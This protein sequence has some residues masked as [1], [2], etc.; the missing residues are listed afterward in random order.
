M[1]DVNNISGTRVTAKRLKWNPPQEL[2]KYS[3]LI[4]VDSSFHSLQT[5][6][7][8][9]HHPFGR[10]NLEGSALAEVVDANPDFSLFVRKNG[11]RTTLEEEV[12]AVM[13]APKLNPPATIRSWDNY[14]KAANLYPK[15]NS[16][17]LPHTN[18]FV[19][20]MSDERIVQAGK[21]LFDVEMARG[22]WR[23]QTVFS[24]IMSLKEHEN[25]NVM[26]MD[27]Q[28]GGY[29]K[30]LHSSASGEKK[31][32]IPRKCCRL[33]HFFFHKKVRSA[34]AKSIKYDE[35]LVRHT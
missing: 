27:A 12:R 5:A 7:E 11:Y 17:H 10:E 25:I 26:Y 19:R 21:D 23:D 6:L 8:L 33:R 34:R 13:D 14:L 24:Y 30:Y 32:E 28:W 20:N 35:K 2:H 18:F 9:L 31:K 29:Y 4:H 1:P 15:I 22:L 3:Y 16:M